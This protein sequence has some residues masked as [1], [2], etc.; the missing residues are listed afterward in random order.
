[1]TVFNKTLWF[2][3][4]N[5]SDYFV[6]KTD[7]V[8]KSLMDLGYASGL[9]EEF[10]EELVDTVMVTSD[11]QAY[12]DNYFDGSDDVV[13]TTPFK[14]SFNDA[15]DEYIVKNGIENVNS[16]NRNYLIKE[17]ARI[18]RRT[19]EIP[20]F[21]RISVYFQTI[22][23]YLPIA[24]AAFSAVAVILILVFVFANSWKHRSAKYIYYSLAGAFLS[25]LAAAI[26][27]SVNGG[28]SKINLES[29]ALYNF[30]VYTVNNA[31]IA[32]WF[33]AVVFLLLAVAMFFIYRTIYL[34]VTSNGSD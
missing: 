25:D 24:I 16:N 10:F 29:R 32:I 20:L 13:D 33:C 4:M 19:L 22:K 34:K 18:Y 14:Q 27:V 7:E 9:N 30:V 11:T 5:Q 21:T 15:L 26:F 6:D 12:I 23:K 1:M 17:A 8:K 31:N 28:I 2:D 3:N